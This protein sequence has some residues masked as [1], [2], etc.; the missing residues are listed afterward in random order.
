M[1]LSIKQPKNQLQEFSDTISN[2]QDSSCGLLA[3]RSGELLYLSYLYQATG[4]QEL[5]EIIYNDLEKI[6]DSVQND[7]FPNTFSNGI[8]GFGWFYEDLVQRKLLN[9]DSNEVLEDIDDLVFEWMIKEQ[10]KKNYDY[11]HGA[12]GGGTYFLKRLYS[13]PNLKDKIEAHL[14]ILLSKMQTVPNEDLC[15]WIENPNN[16]SV[17][18]EVIN[19]GLSHG[20]PSILVYLTKCFQ[21]GIFTERLKPIIKNAVNFILKYAQNPQTPSEFYFP[22]SLSIEKTPNKGSRLAW[23]YGD[24]GICCA[25][26]HANQV[27]EDSVL[28]KFILEVLKHNTQIRD[29]NISRVMDAGLCHG[30][31]GVAHIFNRFYQRYDEPTLLEA[32]NY[33]YKMTSNMDIFEDGLCGYK[34]WKPDGW[35]NSS[36]FLEGITGIAFVMLSKKFKI[37]SNWDELLLI[38]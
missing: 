26:W 2:L 9:A 6:F 35:E 18:T 14:E 20:N 17:F 37:E 8:A 4:K 38:S 5:L 34:K 23:C 24:L 33:W 7:Y 28:D 3:G 30:A 1:V 10:E 21:N 16:I 22:N 13:N 12:I 27:L 32:A 31:S 15:F 29:M 11:L 36:S 25:L 19:L